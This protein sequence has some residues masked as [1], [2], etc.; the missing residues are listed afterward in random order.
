MA[1]ELIR[2]R[3]RFVVK[4]Y[5]C[6]AEFKEEH[7]ACPTCGTRY[8]IDL[9]KAIENPVEK[10]RGFR[11]SGFEPPTP[12]EEHH[13]PEHAAALLEE[14]LERAREGDYPEAE[15]TLREAA[16]WDEGNTRILFYWGSCLFKLGRV[17]EAKEHW[18]RAAEKDPDNPR[19]RRWLQKAEDY[20]NQDF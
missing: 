15:K 16:G 19:L 3:F 18:E 10:Y 14:G 7:G 17:L 5:I 12:R 11:T 4:C 13:D 2:G 6:G 9:K 1:G 8:Q 20:L